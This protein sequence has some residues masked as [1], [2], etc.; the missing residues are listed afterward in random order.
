MDGL[1]P[2]DEPTLPDVFVRGQPMQITQAPTYFRLK[3][4]AAWGADIQIHPWDTWDRL[5]DRI[6][7]RLGKHI[8]HLSHWDTYYATLPDVPA[9]A[10][11]AVP[12]TRAEARQKQQEQQRTEDA[13]Y[14]LF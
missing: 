14:A 4:L 8:W 6:G 7:T 1:H 13:Q 11:G 5:A 3:N 10:P 9:S 2:V 12:T